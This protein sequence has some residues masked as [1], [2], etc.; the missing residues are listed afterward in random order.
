MT[1]LLNA[2]FDL[3]LSAELAD[4]GNKCAHWLA[5]LQDFPS[6]LKYGNR[7]DQFFAYA[8]EMGIRPDDCENLENCY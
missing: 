6:A 4:Y 5:Y 2:T 1:L 8:M 3:A 7:M